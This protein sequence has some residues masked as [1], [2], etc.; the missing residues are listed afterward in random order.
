MIMNE[1]EKFDDSM[2]IQWYVAPRR[3]MRQ[4]HLTIMFKDYEAEAWEWLPSFPK[5]GSY[6]SQRLYESIH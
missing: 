2:E 5:G 1:D 6:I 4:P 3:P